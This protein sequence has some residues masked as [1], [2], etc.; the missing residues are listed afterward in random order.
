MKLLVIFENL[1]RVIVI[2][3]KNLLWFKYVLSPLSSDLLWLVIHFEGLAGNM[4]GGY[5]PQ[6]AKA[7]QISMF[8]FTF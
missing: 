7:F 5:Q 4:L 6:T 2:D 8:V 3:S 1:M